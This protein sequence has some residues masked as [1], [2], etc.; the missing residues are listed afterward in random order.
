MEV[1]FAS[2]LVLTLVVVVLIGVDIFGHVRTPHAPTIKESAWWSLAYVGLALLFAVF[3][4]AVYGAQFA[5]QYLAGWATEKALSI[6]NLFVFVIIM[7]SFR[8]PRQYQQKALLSGIIIALVLRL[9]FILVGA[10]IID[11]FSWVF[12]LF[13]IWLVYVAVTQVKAASESTGEE[14]DDAEYK[15]ARLT[16]MVR[17]ILPVTE[18]FK[19]DR[20]L[21]RHG[22]KTYVTPLLLVVIALGSADIMFALDSIP[23]IFGLTQ[24]P[25]LV[26]AANALALLGLRQLYFLIDGLLEK[27]IY[28]HWGLAF[29]LAFIGAKLFLHAAHENSLP[30]INNGQPFDVPDIGIGISLGTIIGTIVVTVIASLI[31]SRYRKKHPEQIAAPAV[32][33]DS[34]V[35]VSAGHDSDTGK[36]TAREPEPDK[37]DKNVE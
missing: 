24:Q 3:I 26:F 6:D 8:V 28:L 10:A 2:W 20:F 12:Y 29:I 30:F 14:T 16:R 18:G 31:G 36:P 11:R 33:Q 32:G 23:A 35:D 15:E 9:V 37:P 4:W 22:G 5:G 27:L 34:E 25:Y 21:F 7:N 13:G 19:G 17:R 1:H